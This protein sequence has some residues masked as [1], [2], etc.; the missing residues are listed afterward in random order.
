MKVIEIANKY[1]VKTIVGGNHP[2]NEL[3]SYPERTEV[4]CGEYESNGG[5][6]SNLDETPM[7]YYDILLDDYSPNGYGHIVSS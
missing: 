1:K 6:L 4:F 2:T 5:R 7:P 3:D